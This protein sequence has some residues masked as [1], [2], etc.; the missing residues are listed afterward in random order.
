MDA[1]TEPKPKGRRGFASM[2]TEKR[3]AIASKGGKSV[4]AEK[5]SFSQSKDL[6]SGAGKIGGTS[7]TDSS[8]SFF[9]DRELAKSAGAVG[10]RNKRRSLKPDVNS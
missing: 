2:S 9:K 1:I 8:R 5:R 4:P 6:A 10:G 3:R 7:V